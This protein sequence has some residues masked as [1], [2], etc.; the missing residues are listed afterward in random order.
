M[1]YQQRVSHSRSAVIE[2]RVAST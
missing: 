1:T 2:W